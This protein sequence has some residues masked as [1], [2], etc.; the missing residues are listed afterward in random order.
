MFTG[1]WKDF[2][3]FFF[4]LL[5]AT[6]QENWILSRTAFEDLQLSKLSL[7]IVRIVRNM[8][9]VLI[10]NVTLHWNKQLYFYKWKSNTTRNISFYKSQPIRSLGPRD[11]MQRGLVVLL[12][13]F[14]DSTLRWCSWLRHCATR[15]KVAGSIR[16]GVIGI[17][18]SH[19]TLP[20]SLWPRGRLSL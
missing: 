11:F 17:F 20:A 8:H 13:T 4:F 3:V 18:H 16:G 19:I 7:L 10:I 6:S 5:G 15:R 14:R 2:S 1:F 12:P 9:N